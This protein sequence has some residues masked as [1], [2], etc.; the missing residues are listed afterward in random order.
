MAVGARPPGTGDTRRARRAALFAALVAFSALCALAVG[1][2]GAASPGPTDDIINPTWLANTITRAA[3]SGAT[4]NVI[5][6]AITRRDAAVAAWNAASA[7]ERA[8]NPFARPEYT[9][10]WMG[11][12]N[13]GDTSGKEVVQLLTRGT[14]SPEGL[15]ELTNIQFGPGLDGFG[16]I[17]VRKYDMDGSENPDYG[18]I[19]NFVQLPAPWSIE[20]EPHHMQY[21]WHDGDPI[22]AGCLFNSAAFV[23][24]PTNM[25]N[26]TL[27]STVAP[28]DVPLGS[29]FDAFDGA[30]NGY[31][32]GTQM[33]GPLYNFG[34]S[35][36]AL[37]TFKK[38]SVG[39]GVGAT[40]VSETPAGSPGGILT[41]NTTSNNAT[42]VPEP[43]SVREAR[44]VLSCSNPHGIQARPD[45]GYMITSDYAEPRELVLDP[46][47]PLDE[48]TFRPTIRSWNITNPVKPVLA[49]VSHAPCCSLD[50]PNRG[51]NDN[52]GL[53]ETGKTYGKK[54]TGPGEDPYSFDPVGSKGAFVESMCGGGIFFT[55]DITALKGD[56]SDKW[57][58]VWNDGIAEIQG[59]N[60]PDINGVSGDQEN[61]PGG[62]EGGAW[63]QLTPNNKWLF[64][65]LQ[66]RLPVSDNF[67]D[68]G[69]TKGVYDV[70]ISQMMADAAAGKPVTCDLI[71]GSP[72]TDPVTHATKQ[73][74]GSTT[75]RYL[76][77]G[78][79]V[80]DCP[81]FLSM[82]RVNDNTTGGPHWAGFDNHAYSADGYPQRMEIANY[83]VA[84][85]GVDGNHRIMMIDIG[86]DGK[87]T[88]DTAFRDEAN[89]DLGVD[90][91]RRNW[92]GS[93]DAGFYKPHSMVWI[94]APGLADGC[95]G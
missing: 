28:T 71:K 54:G 48:H 91:N 32:I 21:D 58:E 80:A 88:Y 73:L 93:P 74:D 22:I 2:W 59:S 33:G 82:L 3:A 8:K 57:Q 31:F 60:T 1:A 11:K 30:G 42:P 63:I 55:P 46:V 5:P 27:R 45:L 15:K 44:P 4:N 65:T 64:R 19:V 7:S 12:Q 68:T 84:R 23:L 77:Q 40:V 49:S 50:R 87:L 18:R 51:H 94:C 67:F 35:P 9:P 6:G 66:G 47:K 38:Q 95:S 76:S 16:V 52:L 86:K 41:G 70:D 72:Y 83:F 62:C 53:M 43:C 78:K 34:G 17:D 92:P 81:R 61:E 89:G 24:D 37:V 26:M 25:P 39:G 85:T 56:A 13:A 90:F 36:G 29:I 75:F 10:I 79:Q 69:G 14:I 20:C